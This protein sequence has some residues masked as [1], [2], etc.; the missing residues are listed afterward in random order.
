MQDLVNLNFQV[1]ELERTCEQCGGSQARA[2]SKLARLPRVLVLYLKRHSYNSYNNFHRAREAGKCRTKVAIP[3]TLSFSDHVNL[4]VR[5]PPEFTTMG[6]EETESSPPGKYRVQPPSETVVPSLLVH[7]LK[8]P[9]SS[10]SRSEKRKW[11]EYWRDIGDS[12]LQSAAEEYKGKSLNNNDGWQAGLKYL[13]IFDYGGTGGVILLCCD[14]MRG[15]LI[16][17]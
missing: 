5:L 1:E 17:G 16:P 6:D 8:S 9:G 10:S 2:Q 13:H 14:E 4:T 15:Y 11:E 12:S 7:H 3:P